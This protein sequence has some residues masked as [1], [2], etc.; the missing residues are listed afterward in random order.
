MNT[1]YADNLCFNC[2]SNRGVYEVC[3]YCG[4]VTGSI[5]QVGYILQPGI[6]LWGRYIIGTVLGVGGFGITYRAWDSRLNTIVAIKEF[7]PRE[8]IS[9]IP[10]ESKV[11]I[12]SGDKQLTYQKQLGRF[13][14]EAKNLAKFTGDAHIVNVLDYF[15]DNGTAYIVMEYLEGM[16]LKEYMAAHGGKLPAAQSVEI[17]TALLQATSRI[18]NMG[19]IHRDI[20]PDNIFIL[21]SGNI[22]VLDFGAAQFAL[23][24]TS[25]LSHEVVVKKGYAPPEQY[26]TN[27]KQGVW[28][29]I[30]AIG[31]TLYKMTTGI[32]PEES[33]ERTEKDILKRPSQ[34]GTAVDMAIDKAVMKAMALR[35]ELRFKTAD[36]MLAALENRTM[37]DFPEEELKK[38]RLRSRVGVLVSIMVVIAM[39]AL[40]AWQLTNRPAPIVIPGAPSLADMEINP[41]TITV[42]VNQWEAEFYTAIVDAFMQAY[43]DYKVV[44]ETHVGASSQAEA[45]R[46]SEEIA[47]RFLSRDAPTVFVAHLPAINNWETQYMADLSMLYNAMDLSEYVLLEEFIRNRDRGPDGNSDQI[48]SLPVQFG[49]YLAYI[50]LAGIN[51][52]GFDSIPSID[53]YEQV[54]NWE[55]EMPGSI[56]ME[57]WFFNQF[58]SIFKP[59]L[60]DRREIQPVEDLFGEY[61]KM[62]QQGHFRQNSSSSELEIRFRNP[63]FEFSQSN[64]RNIRSRVAQGTLTP[65]VPLTYDNT[66]ICNVMSTL[67][68]S[69][70][71][72]V[73]EQR[74]GMLFLHYMLSENAQ[75]ILTVQH[76]NSQ[77]L[78]KRALAQYVNL[79]PGFDFLIG[80]NALPLSI[81]RV[82]LGS[83]EFV[84]ILQSNPN[85]LHNENIE[86]EVRAAVRRE[87]SSRGWR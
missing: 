81:R 76:D 33:I 8:L 62:L 16:T 77:P 71:A 38:R 87:L 6:R 24:D 26:R 54:I 27:M 11:R 36:A 2:F 3:P 53:S 13:I 56:R 49:F 41:G 31:A 85:A 43:P 59:E 55:Y 60:N 65:F 73:N 10:G 47:D 4:Y 63:M 30:Y 12:F 42:Y 46:L 58:I 86:A 64:S 22:K 69:A 28:T 5:P 14:D 80:E 17:V 7:F 68:V 32:T 35:P 50:N 18:H 9:R 79:N 20:S 83:N 34:T 52:R 78:N 75:N 25:G 84:Q 82:Y 29:D 1:G 37:I 45:Q 44:L 21:T 57:P 23:K 74:I 39:G 72:P 70:F 66:I 48:F 51:E 19:I 15:E 61:I 67:A 40:V